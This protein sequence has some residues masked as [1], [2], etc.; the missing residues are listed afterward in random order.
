MKWSHH[1]LLPSP[2]PPPEMDKTSAERAYMECSSCLITSP[3]PHPVCPP[4]TSATWPATVSTNLFLFHP[5]FIFC[6]VLLCSFLQI[7]LK[8]SQI[9]SVTK[10]RL[11]FFS[12]ELTDDDITDDINCILTFINAT[13]ATSREKTPAVTFKRWFLPTLLRL[14]VYLLF[15]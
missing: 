6:F 10:S 11:Y 13:W 14:S 1:N 15:Q 9:N 3:A 2:T 7:K 5:R 8:H 12:K 4:T